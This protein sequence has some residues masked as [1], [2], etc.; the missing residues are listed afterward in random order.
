MDRSKFKILIVED[1][2][3]I[4]TD[5]KSLLRHE[6]FRVVGTANNAHKALDL[7]AIRAPNF[8]ILDI[9]LGTGPTGIEVA[10][11]IHEKYNIPYIFLTSYS[12]E[13]TLQDAQEQGPY[14]YL[15]K[16]YQ[17][18]TLITTIATAWHTYHRIHLKATQD[19][20]KKMKILTAQEQKICLLLLD[21][22]SYKQICAANHISI[23]TLKFHVKNI[24]Q[25]LHVVGRAQLSSLLI[26]GSS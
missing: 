6:E 15:V 1:D 3:V 20:M 12:D 7:L 23:N 17:D 22:L 8:V 10:E 16:P 25:K 21:G 9:L 5:L 14:G 19:R 2:P 24:Y 18:H 13:E 11:V 26:Q 4:I